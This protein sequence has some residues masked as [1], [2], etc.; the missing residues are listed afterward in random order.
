MLLLGYIRVKQSLMPLSCIAVDDDPL[1]LSHLEA[2]I[3]EIPE[4]E[5]IEGYSQPAQ[6]ATA[7][8]R[9]HPDLLFL[10]LEMPHIEGYTLID[11]ILPRLKEMDKIPKIIVISG[12]PSKL[13]F[14]NQYV[15][16]NLLKDTFR[17]PEELRVFLEP[18][19]VS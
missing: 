1:F 8:I 4:I 2:L 14:T 9:N 11:W 10:D 3:D 13:D 7:I 15:A 12:Q 19:I 16:L 5:W 17:S 6:A 18:V